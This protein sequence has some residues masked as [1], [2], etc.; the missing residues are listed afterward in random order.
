[1]KP[2]KAMILAAGL[3]TRARPLTLI[4]PKVLLPVQNRP[5]LHW[6]VEYLRRA[7]AEAVVVNAHHLSTKLAEHVRKVDFGIPVEVRVEE[8][9]LGTGGGIRNVEDFWDERPFVVVNGDILSTIDLQEALR[10][11]ESSGSTVT[12]VLMDEPRFHSVSVAEDGRILSFAG[13]PGPHLAFTGIHVLDPEVLPF[14]PAETEVSILDCYE[15]LKTTEGKVMAHVVQGEFWREF[16]TLDGYLQTHLEFFDMEAAPV[17][18]LQVNGRQFLHPS[19]VLEPG[20]SLEGMVCLGEGCHLSGGVVVE[21]SVVWDNVQVKEG[22]HIR[23]S[24]V[25]DGVVVRE[26]V[27]GAVVIK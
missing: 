14:I 18:G 3:G 22:C 9:I 6:L 5:L 26:S 2:F 23:D 15:T 19:V 4:R 1:M 7:G 8:N 24:I 13:G 11:H 12:L 27:E 25:G 10:S 20:V 16:G 17:R 21:R